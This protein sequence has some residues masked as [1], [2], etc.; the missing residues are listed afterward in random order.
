MVERVDGVGLAKVLLVVLFSGVWGHQFFGCLPIK[1][2]EGGVFKDVDA[3]RL[4]A[5]RVRPEKQGIIK[6]CNRP[7]KQGII[8]KM[9]ATLLYAGFETCF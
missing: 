6:K 1:W 8:N 2:E 7:E 4:V 5:V 9:E 3:M